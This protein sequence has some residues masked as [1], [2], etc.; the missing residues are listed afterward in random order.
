MSRTVSIGRALP[1]Y[2]F[3]APGIL[4][5]TSPT[6]W[7]PIGFSRAQFLETGIRTEGQIGTICL[8]YA[9]TQSS[10]FSVKSANL[11]AERPRNASLNNTKAEKHLGMKFSSIEE[12]INEVYKKYKIENQKELWINYNKS[13]Y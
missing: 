13:A 2:L 12:G 7:N 8:R 3:F 5:K 4:G 11:I 1:D 6:C 10:S 9:F